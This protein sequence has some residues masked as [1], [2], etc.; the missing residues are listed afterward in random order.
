EQ[1]KKGFGKRFHPD[2][3]LTRS[4]G[5]R[6]RRERAS[7][8]ELFDDRRAL[9]GPLGPGLQ[10]LRRRSVETRPLFALLRAREQAG[11]LARPILTMAGSYIH[12]HVNRMLRADAVAQEVVLYD[13]LGRL[14][15]SWKARS[16][17]DRSP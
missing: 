9:D 10:E 15:D 5:E 14:Y 4:I 13:F 2:L 16:R 6:F 1:S 3:A 11:E 17:G 7:L 8:D 12:M